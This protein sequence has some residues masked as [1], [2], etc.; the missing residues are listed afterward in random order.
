MDTVGQFLEQYGL[1]AIFT[2]LLV[3]GLGV[4][5][6][7]PGDFLMLLAG[8]R[9]GTGQYT[10]IEVIAALMG[11]TLLA[12]GIQYLLARGPSRSFVYRF[13]RYI[14]LTP[15]R[16]DRA[17][18]AVRKRGAAAVAVGTCTPGLGM[19]TYI[20]SGLAELAA[21]PFAIGLAI[22]STIFVAL[23]IALGYLFGPGVLTAL[24]SIHLP[25]LPVAIG[26]ALLGLVVW[27]VRTALRRRKAALA[28]GEDDTLR[29]LHAW[30]E[31]ACPVCMIAGRLNVTDVVSP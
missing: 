15:P 16:L 9:A 31:A 20:A 7:V 18:G 4:P 17:A 28:S 19:V 29:T 2:L 27:L 10:L 14:G 3:K 5:I 26:L 13:G 6:P 12:A 21:V 23:H 24:D 8:V 30:T 25:L 1:L 11:A 22:G